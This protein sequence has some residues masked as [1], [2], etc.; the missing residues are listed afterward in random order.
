MHNSPTPPS[1]KSSAVNFN[2]RKQSGLLCFLCFTSEYWEDGGEGVR[3]VV[4][5]PPPLWIPLQFKV[6]NVTGP[7]PVFMV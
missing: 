2:L 6:Q 3:M 5:Y 7:N 1:I 4:H